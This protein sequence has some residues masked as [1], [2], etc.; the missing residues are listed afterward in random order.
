MAEYGALARTNLNW[1]RAALTLTQIVD[2]AASAGA[3]CM[4]VHGCLT[5][6]ACYL[7]EIESVR[8][9]SAAHSRGLLPRDYLYR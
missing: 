6:M 1:P 8:L 3:E 4:R 2:Q 5:V 9:R 7:S